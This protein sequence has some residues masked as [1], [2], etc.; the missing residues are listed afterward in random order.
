MKAKP[1]RSNCT[2]DAAQRMET[3]TSVVRGIEQSRPRRIS[4]VEEWG[5]RR[6]KFVEE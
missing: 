6:D 3:E 1:A 4:F 5:G 2:I